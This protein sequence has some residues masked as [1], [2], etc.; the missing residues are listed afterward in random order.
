[1]LKDTIEFKKKPPHFEAAYC[2]LNDETGRPF[3]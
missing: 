3:R 1:M 2:L